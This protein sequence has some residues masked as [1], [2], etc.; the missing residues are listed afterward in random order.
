MASSVYFR[1]VRTHVLAGFFLCH[2]L[3][4]F[5]A[6]GGVS[7]ISSAYSV[8]A[9]RGVFSIALPSASVMFR[10]A[11]GCNSELALVPIQVSL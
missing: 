2:L 9:T 7:D 11:F 6:S 8:I 3:N 4:A 10:P 1:F 5:R